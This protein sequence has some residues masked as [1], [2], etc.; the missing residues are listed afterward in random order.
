M[1]AQSDV[2]CYAV[3]RCASRWPLAGTSTGQQALALAALVCCDD[4]VMMDDR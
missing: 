3:T 1:S 4:A 2:E